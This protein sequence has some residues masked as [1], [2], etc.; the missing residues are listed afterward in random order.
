MDRN[1][2]PWF[3]LADVCRVIGHSNPSMV[4]QRLDDDEKETLSSNDTSR[5]TTIVSEPGLYRILSLSRKAEAE[6]FDRQP[7]CSDL[8]RFMLCSLSVRA[9]IRSRGRSWCDTGV[10][11]KRW[12]PYHQCCKCCFPATFSRL[13]QPV[14]G[15]ASF[16][17]SPS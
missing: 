5:D 7:N 14:S 10:Q 4:A 2:N 8:A 12:K 3:V 1:G 16:C 13:H 17:V 6:R 9:I 11:S 15:N